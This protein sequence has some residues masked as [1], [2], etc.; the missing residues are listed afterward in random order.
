MF[1]LELLENPLPR[2][3]SDTAEPREVE[4]GSCHFVPPEGASVTFLLGD[5]FHTDCLTARSC[6]KG[7]FSTYRTYFGGLLTTLNKSTCQ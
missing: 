3:K 5:G 7:E 1:N 4:G 2:H 6:C